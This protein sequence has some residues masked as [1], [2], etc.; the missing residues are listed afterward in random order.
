MARH[1][2][3]SNAWNGAIARVPLDVDGALQ[4]VSEW[5][6]EADLGSKSR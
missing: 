5:L 4:R 2:T 1:I 6:L 3:T